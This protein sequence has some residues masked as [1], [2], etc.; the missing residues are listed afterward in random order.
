M[1]K[2]VYDMLSEISGFGLF[3][4]YLTDLTAIP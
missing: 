1:G 2:V 3:N 4:L